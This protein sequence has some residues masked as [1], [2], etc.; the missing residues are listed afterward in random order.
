MIT[1]AEAIHARKNIT[2]NHFISSIRLRRLNSKNRICETLHTRDTTKGGIT[3][4]L[5]IQKLV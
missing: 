3:C 2:R 1:R 5:S 4:R